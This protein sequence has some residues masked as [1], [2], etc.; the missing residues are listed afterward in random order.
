[1]SKDVTTVTVTTSSE[2]PVLRCI[3]LFYNMKLQC[4]FS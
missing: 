4:P 3:E 1:M 2:T